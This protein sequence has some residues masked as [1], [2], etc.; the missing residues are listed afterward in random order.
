MNDAFKTDI[1]RLIWLL[2]HATRGGDTR[3]KI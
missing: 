1:G 2:L 3:L